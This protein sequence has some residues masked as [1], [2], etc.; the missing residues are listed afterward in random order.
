MGTWTE[1]TATEARVGLSGESHP[2]VD[3]ENDMVS[4][5]LWVP[6]D[7]MAPMQSQTLPM[8]D[9][10]CVKGRQWYHFPSMLCVYVVTAGFV[11]AAKSLWAPRWFSSNCF[12]SS[13]VCVWVGVGGV[14]EA[15]KKDFI[16]WLSRETGGCTPDLEHP[17]LGFK[18]VTDRKRQ[19]HS[20]NIFLLAALD[21]C[22]FSKCSERT[23]PSWCHW[24]NICPGTRSKCTTPCKALTESTGARTLNFLHP[25]GFPFELGNRQDYHGRRMP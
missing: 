13:E 16:E 1:S 12:Q 18:T 14:C 7:F 20:L 3:M 6:G 15:K 5:W 9:G 11:H 24:P 25:Q 8:R 2:D 17:R 23:I 10:D 22:I 21:L 19:T 4:Q